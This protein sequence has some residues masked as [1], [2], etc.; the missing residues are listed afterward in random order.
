LK[1]F[2]RLLGS[3]AFGNVARVVWLAGESPDTATNGQKLLGVA[4]SNLATKP[5]VLAWSRDEDQ[6]ITWHGASE[7]SIDDVFN[8]AAVA[9]P[10]DNAEGWLRERLKDGSVAAKQIE[11]EADAIG[12][13][14]AT[15]RRAREDIGIVSYRLSGVK[16]SPYYWRLPEGQVAHSPSSK[17]EQ[18]E[19]PVPAEAQ[20]DRLFSPSN[21]EQPVDTPR[22]TQIFG[23]VAQVVHLENRR[24]EQPVTNPHRQEESR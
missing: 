12:F 21:G 11:A 2:Q 18:P 14:R 24:S 5:P 8:T 4:K 9:T 1:A 22:N 7:H 3:S 23:Q 6:P 16:S 17:G 19:Q 20:Q 13:S 10:R 15:L